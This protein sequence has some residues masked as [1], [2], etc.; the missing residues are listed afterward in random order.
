MGTAMTK[1]HKDFLDIQPQFIVDKNGKK[2]GVIMNIETFEELIEKIEELYFGA[3]AHQGMQ[4]KT[5]FQDFEDFKKKL[6]T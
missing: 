2:T 3:L 4:D 5:Q 1:N 6:L